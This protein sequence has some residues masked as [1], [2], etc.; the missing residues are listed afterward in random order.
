[1][2]FKKQFFLRCCAEPTS[3]PNSQPIPGCL[4]WPGLAKPAPAWT[5]DTAL[6]DPQDHPTCL[7]GSRAR[8]TSGLEPWLGLHSLG[9]P[10]PRMYRQSLLR[11]LIAL[12]RLLSCFRDTLKSR[13]PLPCRLALAEQ[14]SLLKGA[15]NPQRSPLPDG[16]FASQSLKSSL[17]NSPNALDRLVSSPVNKLLAVKCLLMS[18]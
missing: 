15:G 12:L 10:I 17:L 18:I 9:L 6:S 3:H 8:S 5:P 7:S 11:A 14:R 16:S 2:S 13:C 4:V 1:M